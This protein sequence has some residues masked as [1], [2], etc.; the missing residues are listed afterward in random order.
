M[1]DQG[2][3]LVGG[4][5]WKDAMFYLFLELLISTNSLSFNTW[6]QTMHWVNLL[7]A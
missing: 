7:P 2:F 4:K 1:Q 3:L 6:E 5:S